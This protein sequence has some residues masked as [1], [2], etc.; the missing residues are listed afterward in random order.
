[1]HTLNL[2]DCCVLGRHF[3]SILTVNC[4]ELD[5]YKNTT[6]A[7]EEKAFVNLFQQ[8]DV[9]TMVELTRVLD[10]LFYEELHALIVFFE[11]ERLRIVSSMFQ[12]QHSDHIFSSFEQS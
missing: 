8:L 2:L 10:Q 7:T 3:Y 5:A 6:S 12:L 9:E 4:P 1:M 11:Q